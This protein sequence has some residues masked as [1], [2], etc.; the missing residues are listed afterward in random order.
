CFPLSWL[1]EPYPTPHWLI[2]LTSCI[3]YDIFDNITQFMQLYNIYTA[4][5]SM[6]ANS[7]TRPS[8]FNGEH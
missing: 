6:R 5:K 4:C 1:K 8:R 2:W 3:A 7:R